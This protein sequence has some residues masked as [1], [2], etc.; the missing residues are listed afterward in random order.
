M[1][2]YAAVCRFRRQGFYQYLTNKGHPWKYQFL[3][4]AMM[5]ILAQDECNDTYGR[6]CMYQ[7]L[8]LKQP[9]NIEIPSERTVYLVMERIGISHHPRRKPNGIMKADKEAQK[10]DSLLKRD[11]RAEDFLPRHTSYSPWRYRKILIIL[12]F[13]SHPTTGIYLSRYSSTASIYCLYILL[14][15]CS[16]C[17]EWGISKYL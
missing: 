6:I 9:P 8:T 10:S 7:A 4:D 17:P 3:A 16:P 5:E 12:P 13:R 15:F 11:S 1:L 14:S 2:P